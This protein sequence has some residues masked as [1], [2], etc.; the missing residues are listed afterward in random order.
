MSEK[1]RAVVNIPQAHGAVGNVGRG[2]SAIGS[3]RGSD[4]AITGSCDGYVRLWKAAMGDTVKTRS[5]SPLDKIPLNGYVNGIAVGPKARFCVAAV[6]QE[7]KLGRW[8]RVR[9][10][11]NRIAI[12]RLRSKEEMTEEKD[13][14]EEFYPTQEN[15]YEDRTDASDSSD[16]E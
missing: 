10:A 6:G 9:G 3:L 4:L 12:L 7:P 13:A 1:K 8:D 5:L 15:S 11:K 16:Y 2:I 14:K